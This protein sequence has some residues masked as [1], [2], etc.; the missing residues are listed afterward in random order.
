MKSHVEKHKSQMQE[1]Y[2]KFDVTVLRAFEA[3]NENTDASLLSFRAKSKS[4]FRR[5][6][7]AR[8]F[9]INKALAEACTAFAQADKCTY[10]NE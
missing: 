8:V 10:L 3:L 1:K 9:K 2:S 6:V 4:S 5:C 7:L